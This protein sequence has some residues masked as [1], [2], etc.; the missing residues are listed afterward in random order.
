M[1]RVLDAHPDREENDPCDIEADRQ[2]GFVSAYSDVASKILYRDS[3]ETDGQ[4][5][6]WNRERAT[7]HGGNAEHG[8]R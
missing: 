7:N 4:D 6:E 3:G 1:N 2:H 5:H 8:Q